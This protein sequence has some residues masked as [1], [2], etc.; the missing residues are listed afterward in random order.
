MKRRVPLPDIKDS[1]L[2]RI[3]A[4]LDVKPNELADMLGVSYGDV[5]ALLG[6]RTRVADI[7]MDEAWYEIAEYVETQLGLLMAVKL[8]LN[9]ALQKDKER[10]ALRYA[11]ALARGGRSS[12]R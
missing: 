2:K 3:C 8:E 6:P 9:A 11:Q 7:D 5:L 4:A 1:F 12:P 10:R